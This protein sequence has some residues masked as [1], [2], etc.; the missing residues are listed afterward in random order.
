MGAGMNLFRKL[1]LIPH[2]TKELNLCSSFAPK[3]HIS[4]AFNR[5]AR[6]V[7][8]SYWLSTPRPGVPRRRRKD[9]APVPHFGLAAFEAGQKSGELPVRLS[10]LLSTLAL[11]RPA[12]VTISQP[13]TH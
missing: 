2:I 8:L 13:L 10:P 7:R 6:T 1:P 9:V 5:I 12:S 3:T 11:V 4:F